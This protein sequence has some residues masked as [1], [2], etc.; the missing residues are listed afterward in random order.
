MTT[1]LRLT[2]LAAALSLA[3]CAPASAQVALPTGGLQATPDQPALLVSP[4]ALL[5]RTVTVR[6]RATRGDAGRTVR[7]ER[8]QP[9]GSW[10]PAATT[11]VEQD[12]T[13]R[14]PWLTDQLGRVT[15]RAVV[16]RGGEAT[17]AADP[18]TA[19]LTVFRGAIASW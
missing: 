15:L 4:G 12:G 1:S 8:L 11:L 10:A 7:I 18:L 3:V 9:D 13:F 16:E 17:A 6:G 2:T 5:D 19:Q 14:A